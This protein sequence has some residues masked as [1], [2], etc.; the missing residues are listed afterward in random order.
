M[1]RMKVVGKIFAYLVIQQ[2]ANKKKGLSVLAELVKSC[3]Y[4][5]IESYKTL[6]LI[7]AFFLSAAT[8]STFNGKTQL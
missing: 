8:N 1:E 4:I 2:I 3:V 6:L 5:S 7:V